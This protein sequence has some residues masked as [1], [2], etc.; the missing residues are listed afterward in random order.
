MPIETSTVAPCGK[1]ERWRFIRQHGCESPRPGR[2]QRVWRLA[3]FALLAA[4]VYLSWKPVPGIE[5]VAWM[6]SSLGRLFDR[7][8]GWKNFIGFGLVALTLLKAWHEPTGKASARRA[9]ARASRAPILFAG[10][11]CFVALLEIGQLTLPKRTC[12]WRDVLA[13]WFGGLVA[14]ALLYLPRGVRAL[15]P[16]L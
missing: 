11:C 5:Q 16:K 2:K 9:S 10:F 15:F 7:N 12:D 3:F 6:P 4:A 13:G 8:D 1:S 14:W